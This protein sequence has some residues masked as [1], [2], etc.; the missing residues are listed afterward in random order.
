MFTAGVMAVKTGVE[1]SVVH[2]VLVSMK[3]EEV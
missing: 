1:S 3:R 2:V